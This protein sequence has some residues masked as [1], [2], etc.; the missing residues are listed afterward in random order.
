MDNNT[1]YLNYSTRLCKLPNKKNVSTTLKL[2]RTAKTLLTPPN[3]DRSLKRKLD[4]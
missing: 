3:L 2:S 1:D 4:L